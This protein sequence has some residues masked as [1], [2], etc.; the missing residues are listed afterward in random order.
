M[1]IICK[2]SKYPNRVDFEWIR[3]DFYLDFKEREREKTKKTKEMINSRVGRTKETR[4]VV[5]VGA[6]ANV[7][8]R[9]IV[10]GANG[11]SR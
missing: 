7:G 5:V 10:A 8:E 2:K 6:G 1:T 3:M 9:Q 4:Q 11:T